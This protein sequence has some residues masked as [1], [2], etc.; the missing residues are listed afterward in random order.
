M[1]AFQFP[2]LKPRALVHYFKL[3]ECTDITIAKLRE[4]STEFAR[5]MYRI[6]CLEARVASQEELDVTCPNV[7]GLDKL[8]GEHDMHG[9]SLPLMALLRATCVASRARVAAP[10]ALRFRCARRDVARLVGCARR[11]GLAGCA[12]GRGARWR[13]R[14]TRASCSRH[15][16][17]APPPPSLLSLRTRSA[18]LMEYC[19]SAEGG[20]K[21]TLDDITQ[22]SS[23]RLIRHLSGFINFFKFE[24][25]RRL[26]YEKQDVH[27]MELL[28]E[29]DTVAEENEAM[30]ERIAALRAKQADDMPKIEVCRESVAMLESSIETK[31]VETAETKQMLARLKKQRD[32]LTDAIE[33][34]KLHTFN[35][36]EECDELRGQ[37]VSSPEKLQGEV[38]QKKA[39][40]AAEKKRLADIES[41]HRQIAAKQLL[42]SR[43]DGDVAKVLGLLAELKHVRAAGKAAETDAEASRRQIAAMQSEMAEVSEAKEEEEVAVQQLRE[44][45]AKQVADFAAQRAVLAEERAALGKRH[46]EHSAA[47][48]EAGAEAAAL[49]AQTI[50]KRREMAEARV[51]M[52]AEEEEHAETLETLLSA[53]ERYD[54]QL[55]SVTTAP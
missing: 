48:G 9:H 22:P 27:T 19:D 44:A 40:V 28:D 46:A 52:E 43:T 18:R 2:L 4:P 34:Q 32:E 36:E 17:T 24:E 6:C 8:M 15:T 41:A 26:V 39:L 42:L 16:P 23:K 14:A 21:F 38:R 45:G 12:C 10:H 25:E 50:A 33:S 37:I 53:V 5:K 1:T 20:A 31:K 7:A 51:R 29:A 11:D 30:R 13:R 55:L 49:R 54:T 3:L 47:Q 35:M